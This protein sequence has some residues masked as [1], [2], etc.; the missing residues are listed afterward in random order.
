MSFPIN[1][2]LG[3]VEISSHLIFELLAYT[4][5]FRYFLKLRKNTNDTISN[6]HRMLILIS[7][8]LGALVFSRVL[9]Y[10]ETPQF[11]NGEF[12]F[13]AIYTS[14]T[15]LGG[16]LGGLLAVEI[17]K[18]VIGVTASSGDLMTYPLLLAMII[19]RVG[20]FLAGLED[21]THGTA[22][23]LPWGIDLGDGIYR[24]PTSLYEILFLAS[25]WVFIFT[26]EKKYVL[27][28]GAKFKLFLFSYCLFRFLIEFIKPVQTFEF[29]LNAIQIA[30]LLGILYYYKIV[31]NPRSLLTERNHA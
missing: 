24:H 27:A 15:I 8:A 13:M 5:G 19:G 25:T 16:L 30:A 21:G 1:I 26:L 22:T 7:A 28:N 17:C 11:F 4:L 23:T 20:C 6:E 12:S 29:G 31:V 18:K 9:G 14:K 2:K 3:S 10:F